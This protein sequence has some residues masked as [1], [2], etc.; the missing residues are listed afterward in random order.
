M[1]KMKPLS[2]VSLENTRPSDLPVATAMNSTKMP[3]FVAF[4]STTFLA[5]VITITTTL[6]RLKV[7]P[8]YPRKSKIYRKEDSK[9]RIPH[10]LTPP[11]LKSLFQ[12]SNIT[13]PLSPNLKSD[14]SKSQDQLQPAMTPR[15]TLRVAESHL[16]LRPQIKEQKFTTLI[17]H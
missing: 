7:L 2:G 10:P 17:K 5:Q 14:H 8:T 12:R 6:T 11:H 3:A 9:R 15:P 16:P 4:Y 1:T 13:N